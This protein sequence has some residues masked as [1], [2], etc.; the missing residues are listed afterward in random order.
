MRHGA[1]RVA[2]KRRLATSVLVAVAATLFVACGSD[3]GSPLSS[4]ELPDQ[5]PGATVPSEPA[6]ELPSPE[7]P[8]PEQ[9]APDPPPVEQPE[10]EQP[11]IELPV[12]E[13]ESESLTTEEWIAVILLGLLAVV[14]V[15]GIGA[16]LTR[17]HKDQPDNSRQLRLDD[18]MRTSRSIHDSSVLSILSI[19]DPV[20]LQ[21]SWAAAQQQFLDLEGRIAGLVV[22][23]PDPNAART[24]QDL[25]AAV[26]GLQGAL[27]SNVSLRLDPSVATAA[28]LVE[29]SKRTVLERNE[30]LEAAINQALYLR[31]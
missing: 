22:A 5:V 16:L 14:A 17:G 20:T 23:V 28:D 24:L 25:G 9:P 31:I 29:Q 13:T 12:T 11:V 18:I 27:G 4:I 8:A 15:I 6:P 1:E 3:A 26:A 10:P 2:T 7:P 19:A 21:T 30:Q